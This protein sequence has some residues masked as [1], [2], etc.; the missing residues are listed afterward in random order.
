MRWHYAEIRGFLEEIRLEKAALDKMD[1]E[2][3]KVNEPGCKE[4]V[5]YFLGCIAD[6]KVYIEALYT[7]FTDLRPASESPDPKTRSARRS[8]SRSPVA[9]R[10]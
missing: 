5:K 3:R 9:S 6:Y 4:A 8:R 2:D 1:P 7:K 10:P